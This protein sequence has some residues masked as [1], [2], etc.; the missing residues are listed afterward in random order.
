VQEVEEVRGRFHG[1]VRTTVLMVELTLDSKIIL[2]TISYPFPCYMV[3][4]DWTLGRLVLCLNLHVF[5]LDANRLA[6]SA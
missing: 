4:F 1:A 6:P 3:I 5:V 2:S